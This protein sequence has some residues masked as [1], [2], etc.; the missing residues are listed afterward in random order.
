MSDSRMSPRI[1]WYRPAL[2][3]DELRMLTRRSDAKG[4]IYCAAYLG[5]VAATGTSIVLLTGSAPWWTIVL[6][7]VVHGTIF[8][9]MINGFHE[10]THGTVF[11]T[12]WL[13]E[14]FLWVFSF[15]GWYSFLGF[16][17]SHTR[18]HAYTLHP[19]DDQEVLLP[20]TITLKGFLLT[21][22]VNPIGFYNNVRQT[23]RLAS[24]VIEGTWQQRIFG[25]GATRPGGP[26]DRRNH[27]RWARLLLFGHA[28]IVAGG[29]ASG[30]WMLPVVT[31]LGR[32]YGSWL[33]GLCNS[34]QHIGLTDNV[35]DFRLCCRTIELNPI[36]RFLY[37]Q[38][39]YHTEHHMYAAVPCYNLRALHL[40]L[41]HDLAPTV[42]GLRRA[43]IHIAE[44]LKRQK[45]DPDYHY[46]PVLPPT[47]GS[48]GQPT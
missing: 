29:V 8:A 24:G 36:V 2:P 14:A 33:H 40:T 43:W 25:D 6:L 17:A 30:L 39:N 41:R 3:R 7:L 1:P 32:F 26:I 5:L 34:T 48:E 46:V 13:N 19:P 38:M 11:R 45:T 27:I 47:P 22:F 35:N 15:L 16:R 21:A 23:I 4:F 18:H 44:I 12:K 9:F 28:A 42:V 20:R 10:L 37:W 31:T